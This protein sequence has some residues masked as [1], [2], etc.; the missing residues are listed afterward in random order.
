MHWRPG[1]LRESE[2]WV[3]PRPRS[4]GGGCV[5][6]GLHLHVAS[7]EDGGAKGDAKQGAQRQHTRQR[8]DGSNG[9]P[10]PGNRSFS[11]G[12]PRSRGLIAPR[13]CAFLWTGPGEGKRSPGLARLQRASPFSTVPAGHFPGQAVLWTGPAVPNATWALL[14]WQLEGLNGISGVDTTNMQGCVR[15]LRARTSARFT[16]SARSARRG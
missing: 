12:L 6:A 16:W 10:A 5:G 14:S 7:M 1:W 13:D 3:C 9:Q 15:W 2:G 11:S 8:Q 4:V